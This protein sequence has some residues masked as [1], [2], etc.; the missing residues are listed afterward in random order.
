MSA[1]QDLSNENGMPP[2]GKY[3]GYQERFDVRLP[4]R[5]WPDQLILKAPAW[6]SVDLRDGNQALANP[7]TAEQKL[8]LY[9]MLVSIGF[10]QIEIG[11]PSASVVEHEFARTLIEERLIPAGVKPQV[12]TATRE[13]LVQKTFE[14]I[15]GG[16]ETIVHVYN[17][18]SKVQRE[19]VYKMSKDETM[20]RAVEAARLV[21]KLSDYH[22]TPVQYQYSPESFTGTERDFARDICNAVIEAW[23]PTPEHKLIINLPATVEMSTSNIFADQVEWISRYLKRRDSVILSVHPHNDRGTAVAAAEL[24]LMAGAER[25]EGT[26]FGNGER[27]GNVDLVILALNL[28]TQG[29]DPGINLK[30]LPK[31][32]EVYERCTGQKVPDRHP[33]GG[34]ASPI[35]YSGTHQ[36]AIKRCLEQRA[37]T[38]DPLWNVAY[39]PIDF[40]DVG[41]SYAPIIIN[42]QSGK[43]GIAYVLETELGF[44]IPKEMESEVSS[45]VQSWCD[46]HGTSITS[47]LMKKLFEEAFVHRTGVFEYCSFKH[48]AQHEDACGTKV[49]LALYIN[50]HLIEQEGAG[51]G[52]I[53]AA[54]DALQK[55]GKEVS[56]ISFSEHSLAA[57]SAASAVAYVQVACNGVTR[58]GVGIDTSTEVAGVKALISA[59]NR[60]VH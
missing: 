1:S 27:A 33:Y 53:D 6:C 45:V 20:E 8:E 36:T 57:G 12:L 50:K 31:V 42:S 54:V 56:V 11:Y 25:I 29:V 30:E 21:R 38:Q 55:L 52:P 34:E 49:N 2:K 60:T 19:I 32:R 47:E 23:E 48:L 37:M 3:Q 16:P 5:T 15:R 43:N 7:M 13:D 17:S 41:R 10:K 58:F 24:A 18:T 35:A 28:F 22:S 51:N 14:S 46:K 40:E 59:L 26:V 9:R 4:D 39:L 44:K